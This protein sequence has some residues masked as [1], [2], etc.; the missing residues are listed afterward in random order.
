MKKLIFLLIGIASTSFAADVTYF[1]AQSL[2]I[3]SLISLC[4]KEFSEVNGSG[5]NSIK[6]ATL[7]E[8]DRS[9]VWTTQ[10]LTI[11]TQE[12]PRFMSNPQRYQL[13]IERIVSTVSCP[14]GAECEPT[15]PQI[16][17]K[18]SVSVL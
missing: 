10:E 18:C 1:D 2:K 16:S 12:R 14:T 4:P 7:I 8:A 11:T 3:A 13:V 15:P 6:S 17:A 9:D 5:Q